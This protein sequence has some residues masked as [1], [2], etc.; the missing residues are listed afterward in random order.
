MKLL[1]P[2]GNVKCQDTRNTLGFTILFDDQNHI[3]G[4][5]KMVPVAGGQKVKMFLYEK[6][7]NV[8][9]S[10]YYATETIE[11]AEIQL[12]TTGRTCFKNGEPPFRQHGTNT[13]DNFMELKVSPG[14]PSLFGCQV[15]MILP[16]Y[17]EVAD[18]P[19]PKAQVNPLNSTF[20]E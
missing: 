4:E 13:A 7:G 12:E 15:F 5:T 20:V 17:M 2:V 1:S 11:G 3:R 14:A 18:A 6:C 9:F 8:E 16:G 19:L 10:Y